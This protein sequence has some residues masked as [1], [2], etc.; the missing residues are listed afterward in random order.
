MLDNQL[1][2][3][4]QLRESILA[5]VAI[6]VVAYGAYSLL[7][8]P[9][10]A[11]NEELATQLQ[12]L[13]DRRAGVEKLIDVLQKKVDQRLNEASEETD[14]NI[15]HNPKLQMLQKSRNPEFK[16]VSDFLNSIT[17]DA[18]KPTVTINS[19]SYD[20][21][22]AHDGYESAKFIIYVNGHYADLID[23]IKLIE[24][25]AA[26]ITLDKLNLLV[27]NTDTTKVSLELNG[28]FYQLRSDDV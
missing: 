27:D 22:Q 21:L 23:F 1:K 5:F 6:L 4:A 7:Y 11:Q 18:T 2:K 19:L 10:S 24:N 25:K 26:L 12:E 28:T 14:A 20:A 16:S 3:Q 13:Q 9:R 17:R 15:S 8:A